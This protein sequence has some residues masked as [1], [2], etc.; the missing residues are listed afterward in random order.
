MTGTGK[1]VAGYAG[2]LAALPRALGILELHPQG[3]PLA[4]L[5]LELGLPPLMY[6]KRASVREVIRWLAAS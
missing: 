4:E 1:G 6:G 3:L 2:R 5:A